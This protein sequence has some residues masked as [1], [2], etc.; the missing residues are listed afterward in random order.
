M[1]VGLRPAQAQRGSALRGNIL[2]VGRPGTKVKRVGMA[3]QQVEWEG[4]RQEE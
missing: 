1:E 2:R 3:A 4:Q